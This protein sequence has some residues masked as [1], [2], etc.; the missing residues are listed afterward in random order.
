VNFGLHTSDVIAKLRELERDAPFVL[1]G[2]G[3]DHVEGRFLSPLSDPE[4]MAE[5]LYALC[6][7]IVDQGTGSVRELAIEIGRL[8]T[9]F[10]WWD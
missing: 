5:R 4:A 8:N 7:D 9:F 2:I 10:C 3:Y 6:P 1:T